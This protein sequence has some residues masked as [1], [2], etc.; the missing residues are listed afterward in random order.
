MA[1]IGLPVCAGNL[2]FTPM[3]IFTGMRTNDSLGNNES[4]FFA[5]L[6]RLKSIIEK[7]EAGKSLFILLDE[8]LK[9]TNTAD[10]HKGSV[11]LIKQL[12]NYPC[13]T[14]IAT[15]DLNLAGMEAEYP[16]EIKNYCFESYVEGTELRFDYKISP[17]IAQNMNATFLMERMGIIK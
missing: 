10:K 9:G 7:L 5:E 12:V 8:I 15:H 1:M 6:K 16:A 17:G 2:K 14:F 3:E 11:A 4:Y 13:F